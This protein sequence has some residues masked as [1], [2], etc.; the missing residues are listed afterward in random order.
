VTAWFNLAGLVTVLAAINVGTFRFAAAAFA[1]D[2]KPDEL[3]QL[4]AVALVTA[5]Q[6]VVNHLGIRVTR[7]LTDFSG[8][9]ILLVAAVLTA[10]LIVAAPSLDFSRLVTYSNF[11][12]LPADGEVWPRTESLVWLFALGFLL[13]AYTI[14]GFDASAHVAEE[15]AG[16]AR[17]VPRG[18]VRSVLVSG[19]F[20]W[21]ML[22]AAVLAMRDPAAAA[23]KGDGAFVFTVTDVLP[24]WLA[25]G[26][27]GGIVVAQYLCGL[28]TVTSASRMAF[29][30]A[31]DG[32]LLFSKAVRRVSPKLRTPRV[33]IWAVAV[34]AVL[35][36]IY[37]PVYSTITAVCVIFLYISY[38]LPTAIGLIAHGRW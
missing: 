36:T 13:P 32:G 8:Y 14:T 16:A 2:V 4:V 30:F 6:A 23:A 28:A 29:A 34:A 31:R 20:G 15:T 24:Q 27:F 25:L 3:T 26:L 12:G 19:L 10:T 17:N 33:A 5:S 35:F 1:P 38:V 9:W 22:C 7:V 11:S 21:V 37:S 18:I